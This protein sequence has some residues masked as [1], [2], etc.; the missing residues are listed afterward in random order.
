VELVGPGADVGGEAVQVADAA[1]SVV[2]SRS[3]RRACSAAIS[4][5]L[6]ARTAR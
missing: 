1:V 5:A 6:W 2:S 3:V 4:R